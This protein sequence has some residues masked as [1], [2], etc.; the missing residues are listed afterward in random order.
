MPFLK[1]M[2][3][4]CDSELRYTLLPLT[5]YRYVRICSIVALHLHAVCVHTLPLVALVRACGE[6]WDTSG[7][8]YCGCSFVP[9]SHC[10]E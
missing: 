10:T 2:S 4:T 3:R 5:I 8:T 6:I 7:G 9:L 1:Q